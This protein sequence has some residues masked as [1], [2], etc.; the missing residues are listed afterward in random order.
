M[1]KSQHHFQAFLFTN[2]KIKLHEITLNYNK[3]NCTTLLY[4]R[5]QVNRGITRKRIP[6]PL[7]PLT[8]IAYQQIPVT[9]LLLHKVC[10]IE[11]IT[12]TCD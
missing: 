8:A 11:T 7:P 9:M 6:K 1:L 3:L 4:I 5:G 2:T 12:L 10:A